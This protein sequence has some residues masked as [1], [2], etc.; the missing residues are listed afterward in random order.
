MKLQDKQDIA[1]AVTEAQGKISE[2][3]NIIDQR[4]KLIKMADS[5]V[6]GWKM[7]AEYEN[8][9]LADNSDDEKRMVK[10]ESRAER[11][12]KQSRGSDDFNRTNASL[13]LGLI[14]FQ[15]T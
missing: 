14:N 11:K 12:S 10:A 4:Q 5:S 15:H 13:S 3:I 2:G 7:V 1:S 8:N 6:H 9:C